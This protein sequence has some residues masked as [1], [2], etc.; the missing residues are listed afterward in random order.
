MHKSQNF[1]NTPIQNT[2]VR[3]DKNTNGATEA[4]TALKRKNTDTSH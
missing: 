1:R 2:L 3:D 4:S